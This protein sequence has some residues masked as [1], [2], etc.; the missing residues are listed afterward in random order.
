MNI[1]GIQLFIF[2]TPMWVLA[3]GTFLAL[4]AAYASGNWLRRRRH[5]AKADA[6]DEGVDYDGY[7]VSGAV[8]LLALLMG[9]TFSLA[10][11][12]FDARRAMVVQEANA[13]GTTYLRAQTFDEPHR[14]E[15]SRLLSKYVDV[16][17]AV[18]QST[19]LKQISQYLAE[20]DTLHASMWTESLAA[21]ALKRDDVASAFMQSMND[22]IDDAAARKAARLA[23]VPPR[24]FTVLFAYMLITAAIL[25]FVVGEM[26]TVTAAT[27]LAL[28][29]GSYM[30]II[31]IDSPNRGGVRESQQA[32]IDL[33]AFI[34]AHPSPS[35]H[36]AASL[37]L[38]PPRP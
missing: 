28:L 32:M 7:I 2:Q 37:A 25:G 36:P 26:R 27:L 17:L 18:A 11:D 30:M 8:G 34:A 31:D 35:F 15:L 38:P 33:K 9:F 6:G 5:R 1:G 21:I 16:R 3:L 20:T 22:T 10:V 29:T 12:R 24:V 14:S 4:S 13:I 19:D 23:H